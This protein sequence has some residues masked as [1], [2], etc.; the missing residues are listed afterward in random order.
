MLT[1][2]DIA[3]IA[4][5]ISVHANNRFEIG[6]TDAEHKD[7]VRII[8]RHINGFVAMRRKEIRKKSAA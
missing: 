6:M 1:K 2:E 5:N 8:E 3:N 4:N 7:F